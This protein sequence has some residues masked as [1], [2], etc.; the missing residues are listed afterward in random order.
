MSSNMSWKKLF[1]IISGVIL[2]SLLFLIVVIYC[3]SGAAEV[4]DST[5]LVE[6]PSD[7]IVFEPI[8]RSTEIKL[9]DRNLLFSKKYVDEICSVIVS[10]DDN[11]VNGFLFCK[12]YTFYEN[13]SPKKRRVLGHFEILQRRS[14]RDINDLIA[15]D[16]VQDMRFDVGSKNYFNISLLPKENNRIIIVCYVDEQSID[17]I[18]RN[19]TNRNS[20]LS[21]DITILA[22]TYNISDRLEK[23]HLFP[24]Y[25]AINLPLK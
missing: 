15:D 7:N 2:L 24:Y 18:S 20:E 4:A 14:R 11:D 10:K 22:G 1:V 6:L 12:K 9:Q 19:L 5:V 21:Y 8:V 13:T 25:N 23:R 17:V 3:I 16:D